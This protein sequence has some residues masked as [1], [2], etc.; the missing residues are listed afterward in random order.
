MAAAGESE[1]PSAPLCIKGVNPVKRLWCFAAAA[2]LVL[3]A[4]SLWA[5][6]SC[7]GGR[8]HCIEPPAPHCPD[9]SDPCC[10]W[11]MPSLCSD[12]H[13]HK[14]IET[15]ECSCDCH[16]RICAARKLGCPLHADFCSCNDVLN[17]LVKALTC[18]TCWE[19]RKTAAWGIAHQNARVPLGVAALY[20]ASKLDHHYLVRD[21]AADALSIL[22]RCRNDCFKDLFKAADVLIV[23]IR[24]DYN[25]TNGNCV[26]LVLGICDGDTGVGVPPSGVPMMGGPQ[27]EPIGG[28]KGAEPLA[29]PKDNEKKEEEKKEEKKDEEKKEEK[30]DDEKKESN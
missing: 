23:R 4:V 24:A 2:A 16:E 27:A 3:S 6:D 21:A 11:R 7:C 18:D 13:V 28:S 10:G 30:K 1:L 29:M 15:L 12:E 19:V 5:G 20:I 26:N 14:L 9:C 25:P 17:A 22:I 8:C